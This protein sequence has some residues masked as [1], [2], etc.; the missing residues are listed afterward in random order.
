MLQLAI[1]KN[2]NLPIVTLVQNALLLIQRI[3][4]QYN[5]LCILIFVTKC[6]GNVDASCIKNLIQNALIWYIHQNV[7]IVTLLQ[8]ALYL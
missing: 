7:P 1:V 4:H 3:L 2:Q 8:N 5:N 6:V